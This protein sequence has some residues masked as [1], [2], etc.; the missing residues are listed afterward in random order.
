MFSHYRNHQWWQL[1]RPYQLK[2]LWYKNHHYPKMIVVQFYGQLFNK[3][4]IL[5]HSLIRLI[6]FPIC[7]LGRLSNSASL[8]CSL[9]RWLDHSRISSKQVSLMEQNHAA[10][11]KKEGGWAPFELCM[12]PNQTRW[13]TQIPPTWQQYH[14]KWMWW[15]PWALI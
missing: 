13:F 7:L 1:K 4:P 2:R 14:W 3:H 6:V 15:L 9:S 12:S 5:G 10:I 11:Y 8:S